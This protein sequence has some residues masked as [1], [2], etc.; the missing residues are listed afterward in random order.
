MLTLHKVIAP[1]S[2]RQSIERARTGKARASWDA[3]MTVNPR[4]DYTDVLSA[5]CLDFDRDI[6]FRM[7]LYLWSLKPVGKFVR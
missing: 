4:P 1:A 6:G 7:F 3:R 5:L 2:R